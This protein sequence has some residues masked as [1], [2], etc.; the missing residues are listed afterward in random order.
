MGIHWFIAA[1]SC[2]LSCSVPM[3]TIQTSAVW[4]GGMV[5]ESPDPDI[6]LDSWYITSCRFVWVQY[7]WL[8]MIILA[9]YEPLSDYQP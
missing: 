6:N 5:L 7:Y 8:F 9:N 4:D 3:L 1:A 2:G